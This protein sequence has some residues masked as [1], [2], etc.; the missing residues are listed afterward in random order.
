M[1]RRTCRGRDRSRKRCVGAQDVLGAPPELGYVPCTMAL[2]RRVFFTLSLPLVAFLAAPRLLLPG[3]SPDLVLDAGGDPRVL[4]VFLLGLTPVLTGY[5]FVEIVAALVP[6]LSR[7][8]HE[9]PKLRATLDRAAATVGIGLVLIQA[10]SVATSIS[11]LQMTSP[12]VEPMEVAKPVLVASLVGGVCVLWFSAQVITRQG[13][14]NGLVLFVACDSIA[15]LVH[16]GLGTVADARFFE[17]FGAR[18]VALHLLALAT[19]VVATSIVLRRPRAIADG[20]AGA[21]TYRD[22]HAL[23]VRPW[24]PVPSSSIAVFP[25][26]LWLLGLPVTLVSFLPALRPIVEPLVPGG[27]LFIAV[28]VVLLVVVTIALTRVLHR[29]SEIT[30]L[31]ESLGLLAA[32]AEEGARRSVV[33]ALGPTLVFFLVLLAADRALGTSGVSVL[34]IPLVVAVVVDAIRSLRETRAADLV[35]VRQER[36]LT[37]VPVL[38]AALEREG[39]PV[40]TRGTAVLSLLQIFAPYAPAEILVRDA[41]AP[42]ARALLDHLLLGAPAPERAPAKTYVEAKTPDARAGRWVIAAAAVP[43]V[44]A[45]ALSLVPADR[46]AGPTK[47][48]EL[49]VLLVDD[50]TDVFAGV[51][52][53]DLPPGVDIRDEQVPVGRD[54]WERAYATHTFARVSPIEGDSLDSAIA[55]A[56][57]WAKT[58]VVPEGTQIAWEKLLEHDDDTQGRTASARTHLLS[59]EPVLTNADVAR[60][61]PMIDDMTRHPYVLVELSPEGA[62]RFHAVTKENVNRR[63]AIVLDGFVTSAPVVAEPISGG[64]ISITMGGQRGPREDLA[65]AEELARA[66]SSASS[67][68]P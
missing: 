8:R 27:A 51:S 21:S 16:A 20:G 55:R 50:E 30:G 68:Q 42:R 15:R 39:I 54:R 25:I 22:A 40:V 37:A 66:L 56:D 36:R 4:S 41:D 35:C 49:A 17:S 5:V 11:L 61:A 44:L 53:D 59:G 57:A 38:C 1:V 65:A 43:A 52:D 67:K 7:R 18:F 19:P 45:L 9:D 47:P 64:R 3:V 26:V 10:Y 58:L 6:K 23:V 62:D 24:V 14:V 13:I 63:L 32:E 2:A 60:A 46:G 34:G 33:A 29:P 12:F 28:E 31:V 48:V